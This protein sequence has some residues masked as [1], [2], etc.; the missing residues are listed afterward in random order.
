MT[1]ANP[2]IGIP[3]RRSN[4]FAS[5]TVIGQNYLTRSPTT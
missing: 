3:E 2:G 1:A 5:T 4:P